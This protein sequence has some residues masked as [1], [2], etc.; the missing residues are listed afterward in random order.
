MAIAQSHRG[1]VLL[2]RN[3]EKHRDGAHDWILEGI[4]WT[5]YATIAARVVCCSVYAAIAARVV[6]C[7]VFAAIA[8]R[9]F[10]SQ[11]SA[12]HGRSNGFGCSAPLHGIPPLSSAGHGDSPRCTR[13]ICAVTTDGS[14][15]FA[16][17]APGAN[18]ITHYESRCHPALTQQSWADDAAVFYQQSKWT[19]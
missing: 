5:D 7:S 1:K 13:S 8:T 4:F 15:G 6:C 14:D 12:E 11:V 16:Q 9:V 10:C 17:H 3:G 18:G 19:V 2:C